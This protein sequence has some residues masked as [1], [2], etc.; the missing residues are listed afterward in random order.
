MRWFWPAFRVSWPVFAAYFPLGAALGVLAVS[1][2]LDWYWAPVF[3][4]IIFAG[5]IE[6]VAIGMVA[7]AM[8]LL[9]V[10]T[11]ALLI[12]F[13]HVFYGFSFPIQ[14]LRTRAQKFYG[15]YALTDEA[16]A[17]A[18]TPAGKELSGAS[19][20]AFQVMTQVYWVAGAVTGA[21]L[22]GFLPPNLSGFEFA[23]TA[24][25]A[26][27]F[28][29]AREQDRSVVALILGVLGAGVGLLSERLMAANTFLLSGMSFYFVATSL[30]FWGTRRRASGEA[31]RGEA[32]A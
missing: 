3:A 25:F 8:P 23:L 22:G 9:Q 10:A 30:W 13:R 1:T 14:K 18:A 11:L 19:L 32:R 16:F 2:G 20:T 26:V 28:L 31:T 24:M 12:N 21:L 4:T 15:I 29:M 7:T 27:L 17:I 5:S 6:F